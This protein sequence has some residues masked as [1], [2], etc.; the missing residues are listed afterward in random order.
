MIKRRTAGSLDDP[1]SLM[2]DN[3]VWEKDCQGQYSPFSEAPARSRNRWCLL[4]AKA[5][6]PGVLAW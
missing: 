1:Y 4:A 3:K 2:T 5:C 6:L